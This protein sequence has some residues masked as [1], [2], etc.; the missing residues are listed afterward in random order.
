MSDV[1]AINATFIQREESADPGPIVECSISGLSNSRESRHFEAY[2]DT[3][4]AI[5]CVPYSVIKSLTSLPLAPR[6]FIRGYEKRRRKIQPYFVTF[7]LWNNKK[8]WKCRPQR[9]VIAT[10]PGTG[11]IGMDILKFFDLSLS[12]AKQTF[13]LSLVEQQEGEM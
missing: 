3:G 11:L 12:V 6:V 10:N 13:Q 9:G 4:A 1:F 2:I 5:S 7:S 8:C